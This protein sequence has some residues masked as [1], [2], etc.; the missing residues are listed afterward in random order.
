VVQRS[1]G[2]AQMP[3]LALQQ[4]IPTLH[5]AIPHVTLN[6][7][8]MRSVHGLWSQ[9]WPSGMQVPQLALQ[10]YWSTLQVL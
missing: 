5:V 4:T 1:P 9:T 10:Q 6:G 7:C 3:Q 2:R 8:V